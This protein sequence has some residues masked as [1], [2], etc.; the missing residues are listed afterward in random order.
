LV[1]PDALGIPAD[2]VK[3]RS[4]EAM[5]GM[6]KLKNLLVSFHIFSRNYGC[7]NT[8]WPLIFA[9]DFLK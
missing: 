7:A 8:V 9:T 3:P 5:G 2:S 4:L 1:L 6:V